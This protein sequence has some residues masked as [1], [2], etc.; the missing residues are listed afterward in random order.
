MKLVHSPADPDQ[1]YDLAADPLERVN[2]VDDPAYADVLAELRAEVA[3]R[4]DLARLDRE[5]RESQRRRRIARGRRLGEGTRD[6]LG[7]RPA[8]RRVAP[9][10]PQPHG[11]R[12]PESRWPASPRCGVMPRRR[13]RPPEP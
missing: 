4:W 7:L 5:V 8:V 6:V 1:L 9:L 3:T 10:H 13:S 12:R 2:L 11:P